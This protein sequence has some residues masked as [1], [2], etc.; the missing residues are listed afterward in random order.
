MGSTLFILN[1]DSH[2]QPVNPPTGDTLAPPFTLS[3]NGARPKMRRTI[4]SKN[5]SGSD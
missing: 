1:F 2:N 4:G 3:L 5:S